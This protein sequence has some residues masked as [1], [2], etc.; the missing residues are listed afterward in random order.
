MK[1]LPHRLL[2]LC[3]Y[4]YTAVM[5]LLFVLGLT[6]KRMDSDD[7]IFL[8]IG[9]FMLLSLILCALHLLTVFTGEGHSPL[10]LAKMNLQMKLFYLPAVVMAVIVLTASIISTNRSTADGAMGGGLAIFLWCLLL[11][12][13][14]LHGFLQLIAG[15]IVCGKLDEMTRQNASPQGIGWYHVLL[16][17]LPVGDLFSAWRVHRK[18]QA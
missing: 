6:Y 3:P 17:L 12:P 14:F 8:T 4:L 5:A 10:A 15:A 2:I 1:K 7:L 11:L 18:L 16:H 9:I 13:I